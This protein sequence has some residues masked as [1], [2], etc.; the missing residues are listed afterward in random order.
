[1]RLDVYVEDEEIG[2]FFMTF[3]EKLRELQKETREEEAFNYD[4]KMKV[5]DYPLADI[6]ELTGLSEEEI[7]AL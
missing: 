3:E 6:Q 7:R 1:M 5:K 4:R 2:G